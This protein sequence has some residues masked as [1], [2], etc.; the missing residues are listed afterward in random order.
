[1]CSEEWS[2][3][4]VYEQFLKCQTNHECITNLA[5]L[6]LMMLQQLGNEVSTFENF[7]EAIESET[8]YGRKKL[9]QNF[10]KCYQNV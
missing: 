8:V 4:K 1:M 5:L 6:C 9:T 10:E 2:Q 7:G 3:N